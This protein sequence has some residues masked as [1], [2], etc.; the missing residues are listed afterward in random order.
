MILGVIYVLLALGYL[1]QF[2]GL[3]YVF[4][5]NESFSS[6]IHAKNLLQFDFFKSYGLTD[7]SVGAVASAHPYVYTHQGNFPRIFAALL[8]FLGF[9]S[10]QSQ[11]LVHLVVVNSLALY[12][13]YAFFAK[14]INPLFA[15][16][17][18]LLLL[19]DYVMHFQWQFNTWRVWHCFFMFSSL[20]LVEQYQQIRRRY[21]LPLALLNFTCLAYYEISYAIFINSLCVLLAIFKYKKPKLWAPPVVMVFLGAAIGFGA[22]ILQDFLY[23][24]SLS[25]FLADLNFTFTARN[26]VTADPLAS[27]NFMSQTWKFVETWNLV[28]WGNFVSS[29]ENLRSLVVGIKMFAHYNLMQYTPLFILILISLYF[30]FFLAFSRRW[31]LAKQ[32]YLI[33]S[34]AYLSGPDRTNAYKSIVILMFVIFSL[35]VLFQANLI[36]HLDFSPFSLLKSNFLFFIILVLLAWNWLLPKWG[37]NRPELISAQTVGATFFYLIILGLYSLGHDRIFRLNEYLHASNHEELWLKLITANILPLKTASLIYLLAVLVGIFIV[38]SNPWY[39]LPKK[40]KLLW[41][42]KPLILAGILA[43]I[44]VWSMMS[45]YLKSGYLTRYVPFFEYF[46]VLFL[47]IPMYLVVE[48]VGQSLQRMRGQFEASNNSYLKTL[49]SAIE[50]IPLYVVCS[51]M[52]LSWGTV[53]LHYFI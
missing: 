45:G 33:S 15:L 52:V 37:V 2:H 46:T 39:S 7:E 51:F 35:I 27:A 5:N 50:L 19:T 13:A 48:L 31:I 28:F 12:L 20:S 23:F 4:D 25:G 43:G 41:R 6:I 26:K 44:V 53:Q 38:N 14:K 30:A 18:C 29:T 16:M 34:S 40:T 1:I 24:G 21:Y 3:P 32:I 9:K 42:L 17:Y 11:I 22:L 36:T 8:Y 47:V 10:I 49:P